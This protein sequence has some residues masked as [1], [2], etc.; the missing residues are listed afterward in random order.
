MVAADRTGAD[1]RAVQLHVSAKGLKV[2]KKAPGP[3]TGVLPEAL[4]KL[5]A[6]TLKRL[7]RDLTRLIRLLDGDHRG[8]T[9]PL[10]QPEK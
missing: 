6:P 4:A 5:D 7:D 1:R 9:I 2:L 8:G 10:G 3:F